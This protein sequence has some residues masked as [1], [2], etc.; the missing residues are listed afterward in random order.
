[1]KGK[2]DTL[3]EDSSIS[4]PNEDVVIYVL[5]G[6]GSGKGTQCS[7]IVSHFGFIH[8]STG[9]LLQ[10]EIASGSEYG[11]MIQDY[12]K[13]GK[14]VPTELVVK[15]L[16]QAMRESKIKKFLIDGFPRNQEN[17]TAAENIMKIEPDI[18]LYFDCT[19]EELIRR[20]LNRNQGRVD[21]NI[22]T[23]KKR[24]KV[25]FDCTLPV[26]DYYSS[27]GK[28]RKMNA[29]KPVEEVFE[30]VKCVITDLKAECGKRNPIN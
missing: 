7:N 1:M 13:E 22:D 26:V 3:N 11:T 9:D 12:K 24:L 10:A 15:L 28:I 2:T 6:P 17:L 29:E 14:L 19:E 4:F 18:V 23:I 5:G 16:Q 8:L 27:K 21:D 30:D 25:F 20:L